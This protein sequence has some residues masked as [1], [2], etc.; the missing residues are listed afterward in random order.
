MSVTV[1]F[2]IYGQT[3]SNK[4]TVNYSICVRGYLLW[5]YTDDG[6]KEADTWSIK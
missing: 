1:G 5:F 4:N 3:K 2:K 6:Q